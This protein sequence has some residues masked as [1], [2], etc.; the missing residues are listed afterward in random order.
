MERQTAEGYEVV[1]V[2]FEN[3]K[4]VAFERFLEG[5]L[6]KKEDGGYGFLA[7]LPGLAVGTDGALYVADDSNGVIYRVT[8]AD[9]DIGTTAARP[10]ST[11]PNPSKEPAPSNIAIELVEPKS[12][13]KIE[14]K[15]DFANGGKL[16]VEHSADGDNSSPNLNWSGAP[17]GTKSFVLMM[18]DPD[19]A[20]PK[21]FVHWIMY[22]IPASV[23]ALREGFPTEPTVPDPKGI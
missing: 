16:A 10:A 7:R 13:T 1:R 15:S 21:P 18:D 22:N 3:G 2:D 17:E 14:V 12:D 9:T 5:F 8:H 20:T 4:P 23:T 11:M 19:A 6:I